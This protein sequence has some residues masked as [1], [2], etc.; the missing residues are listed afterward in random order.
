M[1]HYNN[2]KTNAPAA[3][4]E[5]TIINALCVLALATECG[6]NPDAL[7]ARSGIR[8]D[9]IHQIADRM[10]NAGLWSDDSVD[11]S[12]L[13]D[14]SGDFN[15]RALFCQAQVAAGL[16]RRVVTD[17]GVEYVMEPGITDDQK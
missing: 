14:A 10:R 13:W 16:A 1:N 8:I 7:A 3:S 6:T 12:E 15:A 11:Q 4:E 9:L 5:P 2:S 17:A